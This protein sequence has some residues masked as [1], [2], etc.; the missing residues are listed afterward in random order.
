MS[1]KWDSRKYQSTWHLT[2]LTT[3]LL[4]VP[5]IVNAL[6]SLAL[7]TL[8]SAEIWSAFVGGLWGVYSIANVAEKHSSMT[9][10]Y[11]LF[12]QEDKKH[13]TNKTSTDSDIP[14]GVP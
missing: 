4:V 5:W 12:P 9:P 10:E 3:G 1:N 7:P 13:E 14:I 11:K 8:I 2:W 6:F